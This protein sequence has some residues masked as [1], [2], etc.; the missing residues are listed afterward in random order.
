MKAFERAREAPF[1]PPGPK[2]SLMSPPEILPVP[3]TAFSVVL[4]EDGGLTLSDFDALLRGK[5]LQSFGRMFLRAVHCLH[6]TE[7]AH[8]NLKP[9]KVFPSGKLFDLGFVLPLDCLEMGVKIWY[10]EEKLEETDAWGTRKNF[11]MPPDAAKF[12][13]V[14]E[15]F[16]LPNMLFTL[17]GKLNGFS[18]PL[19]ATDVPPL[20]NRQRVHEMEVSPLRGKSADAWAAGLT[21]LYA[22]T[23]MSLPAVLGVEGRVFQGKAWKNLSSHR[24]AYF[25]VLDLP[26]QQKSVSPNSPSQVV[27][28]I[29]E[30]F[31]KAGLDV[32]LAGLLDV[33]HRWIE[34]LLVLL[35]VGLS[36]QI[37]K[38]AENEA[39]GGAAEAPE[40]GAR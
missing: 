3:S 15:E 11:C 22:V 19:P 10:V 39:A 33:T 17:S 12:L 37:K 29:S 24:Q 36:H 20:E 21:I 25:S 27:P 5:P 4:E 18:T 8:R 23:L 6:Q 31:R 1:P 13:G 16:L 34:R 38:P 35:E 2:L 30:A 14:T 9:S 32:R 7:Y 26:K 40:E 28:C